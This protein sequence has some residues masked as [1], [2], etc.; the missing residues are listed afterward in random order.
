MKSTLPI[1]E[2]EQTLD[3]KNDY[4][5]CHQY[6]F[7]VIPEFKEFLKL[8]VVST[9]GDWPTWYHQKKIVCHANLDQEV[10]S[11]IPEL[12]QFHVYLN[13]SEDVVKKYYPVFKEIYAS[14]FGQRIRLPKKPKPDRVA[15][16]IVL[17]FCDWL[18][19]R[20]QVIQAFG[21][22]KDTEYSCLLHLFEELNPL[23]FLHM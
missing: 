23:C 12:G 19:I 20:T 8:H 18:R 21:Q 22:C 14:V 16:C 9:V 11:L 2:I 10:T 3:S 4:Q 15:L 1:D 17:A 5:A 7:D 6:I 13:S